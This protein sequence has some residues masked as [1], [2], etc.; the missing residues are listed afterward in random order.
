[1]QYFSLDGQ[2]GPQQDF[3]PRLPKFL[4]ELKCCPARQ[5]GQCRMESGTLCF[6]FT[7]AGATRSLVTLAM[8]VTRA[9]CGEGAAS[10]TAALPAGTSHSPRLGPSA[11]AVTGHP[12]PGGQQTPLGSGL[13]CREEEKLRLFP[14]SRL[15][16]SI[17]GTPCLADMRLPV[18]AQRDAFSICVPIVGVK[19]C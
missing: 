8:M 10:V 7:A 12:A 4:D 17:T 6:W 1:M 16:S 5:Q 13:A 9:S 2:R 19:S 14:L 15:S 18:Q 3:S 11:L